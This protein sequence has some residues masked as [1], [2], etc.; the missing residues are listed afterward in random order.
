[1]RIT[2]A[3]RF[4]PFSHVPGTFSI[5][6]AS[7]LRVQVFPSLIRLHDLSKAEPQLLTEISLGVKGPVS[8]FTVQQDLEKGHI[9]IW[10]HTAS[11]YLRYRLAA[12]N[13]GDGISLILEKA[14]TDM[15][16][17]CS[18][19]YTCVENISNRI[20]VSRRHHSTEK[21]VIPTVERLSLGNNKAQDWILIA[22][23]IDMTEVFPLWFRLGQMIPP[24]K[25]VSCDG[26]LELLEQCKKIINEKNAIEIVPAFRNLFL[27]AFDS[28]LSPRL[29]DTE[30]QGFR[31]KEISRECKASPLTILTEGA[32]LIRSL[33]FN[34]SENE[35]HVLPLLPPE[36]HCGRMIQL[37]SEAG[38]LDLEWT[39]KSVRRMIYKAAIDGDIRIVL[40]REIKRFRI[41][42]SEQDKDMIIDAQDGVISVEPQ[43]VYLLDHFES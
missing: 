24:Q 6:P 18:N 15:S 16:I 40:K 9:C 27:A 7:I 39:K 14:P 19:G 20:V 38:V 1:M 36:F 33:F 22:R 13:D 2:I 43:Q 28:G 37:Q 23:R 25:V 35:L 8:D 29:S 41:R 10:G 21:A 4:R 17:K 30:H 34:S 12:L 26:T 5:L 42:K 32:A 3:D 11:G 31:L